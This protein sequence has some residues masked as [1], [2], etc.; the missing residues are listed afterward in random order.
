[1]IRYFRIRFSKP[2]IDTSH[3]SDCFLFLCEFF[4]FF[5][6]FVFLSKTFCGWSKKKK[7][8]PSFFK[9]KKNKQSLLAQTKK[10]STPGYLSELKGTRER[11]KKSVYAEVINNIMNDY[12][13]SKI[14]LHDSNINYKFVSSLSVFLVIFL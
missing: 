14:K 5:L 2:S 9:K 11:L 8:K 3:S 4:F 1:M 6:V 10:Q 7:W 13:K 12:V